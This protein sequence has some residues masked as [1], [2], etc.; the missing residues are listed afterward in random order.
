[1]GATLKKHLISIWGSLGICVWKSPFCMILRGSVWDWPESGIGDPLICLTLKLSYV[2]EGAGHMMDK[3]T[4]GAEYARILWGQI[5]VLF[6]HLFWWLSGPCIA[7]NLFSIGLSSG[8]N[9]SDC[10][11]LFWVITDSWEVILCA[12]F[13]PYAPFNTYLPLFLVFA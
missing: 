1:M 8:S 7:F 13:R 2:A 9:F 10:Q 3:C 12:W 5:V 11:I 6:W 4:C